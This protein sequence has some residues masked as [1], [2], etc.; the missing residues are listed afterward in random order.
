MRIEGGSQISWDRPAA[1]GASTD[2]NRHVIYRFDTSAEVDISRPEAIVA[3]TYSG[4]WTVEA[5]GCYV[6]TALDRANNE[7]GPS[8]IVNVW[9]RR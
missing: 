9:K 1:S 6:V 8:E 7:S 2:V 3:V 5:P 4:N